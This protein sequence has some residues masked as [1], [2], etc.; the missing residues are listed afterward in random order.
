MT[1]LVR[2][3][4]L[5]AASLAVTASLAAVTVAER[6][7]FAQG[8]WWN[9]QRAGTGF[10]LFNVGD[11]AMMIWYTYDESGRAVWYTAQGSVATLGAGQW[12]LLRHR[13]ENGRKAAATEVGWIKLTMTGSERAT[14][15]W[16]IRGA[17]GR[18]TLLPFVASGV[19][20]EVDR[21]GSWFDP[22][23]SGWG[24]TVTEQGEVF[25]GVLYTY[26]PNG[27]PTWAAGFGRER[28]SAELF[29]FQGACPQC[30]YRASTS[31]STGRLGF[32]FNAEW[33]AKLRS[34][35]TMPM[36]AGVNVDGASV[37]QLSRPASSR[38]A[39]RQLASF[40]SASTLK[41]YLDAGMLSIR[42]VSAGADF[43]PA[44]P[45]TSSVPAF[46]STNLQEKD[47]D[48]ADLV[49]TDGRLV[50]TF[51][52][53]AGS[54]GPQVPQPMVR[55]AVV[56]QDGWTLGMRGAVSLTGNWSPS[57]GNTGLFLHGDK[58]VAVGSTRPAFGGWIT[59]G[60]WLRGTYHVE[61]MNRAQANDLPATLWRAEVEGH[62]VATRRIG[63]RLYV[64]SRFV[65]YL[66]NFTYG[67]D[68]PQ[69]RNLL[70]W[71]RIEELLP[72]V[73]VNGGEAASLVTPSS[74]YAPPQGSLAP[75]AD[76]IVVTAIDLAGP[77]IAQTLAII[78]RVE[79]VYAS[80]GNLYVASAR[81]E[82][83]NI[84]GTPMANEPPSVRT[85]VHQIGLASDTMR[86]VGSGSLEGFLGYEADKAAF[87]LSEHDGRLRAI[88]SSNNWWGAS[89]NKLTILEPSTITPGLLRTVSVLPNAAR[90]DP[91]GKPNE[92]LYG[93]RFS[94]DRLYAVTFKK[95]DPLYVIDLANAADPRI[96]GA[97]ELPGFSDYLHPVSNSLLLGFGKDSVPADTTGD[98]QWAWFTGL[99][100]TLFDVS[101]PA[102]PREIQREIMGK[103][104]SESAL[105]R[106]HHAFSALPGADG[107]MAIAVPARI[108]NGAAPIGC[109]GPSAQY[110]WEYSGLMRFELRG[111]TPSSARLQPLPALVTHRS[112]AAP[113]YG[114]PADDTAAST[115][116]SVLFRNGTVYV[117][118]GRFWHLDNVGTM[119]GPQ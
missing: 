74:V 11:T 66:P 48:E 64:I 92:I 44:P 32:D 52:H 18:W 58:L 43:S 76:M 56:G 5:A 100:L 71:A 49:K 19:M 67:V 103:R 117:S 85:D 57:I 14:L 93:T 94:G 87:R 45:G 89:R 82:Y 1:S 73:R 81:H 13:W 113:S 25:G 15:D 118:A 84:L 3:L 61:V 17:S 72:K 63:D 42:S 41:A 69:N 109:C 60:G 4:A 112:G 27:E 55:V 51:A 59:S 107:S 111:T 28:A 95:T 75:L 37:V 2:L 106:S 68:S 115:A 62:I 23:N 16:N 8:H 7:P 40:D 119:V 102:R 9:P 46:S 104:G 53:G 35:L 110:P 98:G 96:A 86:I 78:G 114:S 21:T 39:D 10:D 20:S 12:P 91:I 79:T 83:R 80:T 50:Y 33:S 116:R 101:D 77:R 38:A 6:S 31:V 34:S 65:P 47:V 108:H 99:Q 105:L 29:A 24:L 30:P 90:P 54:G 97:L 22:S 88:S 70:A 26:D 36:A